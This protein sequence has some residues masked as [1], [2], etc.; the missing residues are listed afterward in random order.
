[1]A[2]IPSTRTYAG[3][4]LPGKNAKHGRS[5]LGCVVRL[6]GDGGGS[7]SALLSKHFPQVDLE[8]GGGV[9]YQLAPENYLFRV[10]QGPNPDPGRPV[11][12]F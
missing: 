7:D 9:L 3:E 5:W 6:C 11:V 10:R 2:L 8:L 4:G 1:M 12:D